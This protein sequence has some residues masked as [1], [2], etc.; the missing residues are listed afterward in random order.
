MIRVQNEFQGR[1]A[2]I[3]AYFDF[4]GNVDH[5]RTKLTQPDGQTPAYSSQAKDDL[6]R[7]FRASAFLLLYNLM[8]STVTNAVEAIF[9]ELDSQSVS[10]NDCKENVRSI[11]LDNL[12]SIGTTKALPLLGRI[13]TDIVAKTFRKED[14]VSGNVDAELIRGLAADY[15]F[16]RPDVPQVWAKA[17]SRG[18]PVILSSGSRLSGDGSSLLTVKTHRNRLAHGNTSFSDV[19]KNYTQEDL[20]RIKCEVISYLDAM[21]QNVSDYLAAQMYR[22]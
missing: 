5:G 16:C 11:I 3:E 15:G 13:A 12:K 21:L 14:V 22:I 2:E 6:L 8:E 20:V 10:F 9:D 1:V 18:F 19:G 4:I 7:T 17:T